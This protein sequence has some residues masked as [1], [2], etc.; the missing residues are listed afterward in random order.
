MG[1]QMF[2]GNLFSK[3]K[4]RMTSFDHPPVFVN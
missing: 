4:K 3:L 2:R 1:W